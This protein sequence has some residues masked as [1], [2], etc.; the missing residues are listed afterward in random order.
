MKAMESFMDKVTKEKQKE[1]E[2]EES[3][4]INKVFIVSITLFLIL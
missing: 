1:K 3:E 4:I 2:E